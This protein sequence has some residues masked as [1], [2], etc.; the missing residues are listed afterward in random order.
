MSFMT[1]AEVRPWAKAIR[2]AVP[3]RKMPPWFA[4]SAHGSLLNDR[5]L[6][7]SEIGAIND[8][9]EAGAP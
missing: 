6:S 5:S 4:D 7:K 2:T 1:C 9:V 3:Q 8:W